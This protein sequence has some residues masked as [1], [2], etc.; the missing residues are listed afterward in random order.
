MIVDDGDK[1]RGNRTTVTETKYTHFGGFVAKR[2][3][4]TIA[5][6]FFSDTADFKLKI[7]GFST[8]QSS[9]KTSSSP[10]S[11]IPTVQ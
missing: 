2:G 7:P 10:T 8:E 5:V 4:V 3:K 11:G 1:N 6:M 9:Y